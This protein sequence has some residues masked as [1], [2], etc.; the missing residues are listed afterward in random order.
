MFRTSAV[1][2]LK[3]MQSIWDGQDGYNMLSGRKGTAVGLTSWKSN[4]L[5]TIYRYVQDLG[6]SR[7]EAD[8]KHLGWPRRIQHVVRAKGNRC[9][10]DLLEEQ[11]LVY[12]LSICSGPRR[13]QI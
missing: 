1:P 12:H 13:F 7:S 5:F 10:F 2:D 4:Y 8:A 11:L 6:G 9:R 3:Q